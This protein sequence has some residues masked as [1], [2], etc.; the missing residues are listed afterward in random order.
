M[1]TGIEIA[2]LILGS[3]PLIVSAL[4]HYGEG[5]EAMQDWARFRTDFNAFL[6]D[7]IRQ[8]IFF[9][10]HIEDLLS[11][12]VD[13]EYH[14]GRMLDDST[15]EQWKSPV[16][17]HKLKMRL[18]GKQEYESYMVTV[19]AIQ[20]ILS[21]IRKKLRIA[22]E[23]P[24]WSQVKATGL[25]RLGFE[26]KRIVYVLDRKRRTSL[27]DKLSQYNND[28]HQLLD[29]S[30]RLELTRRKR[31]A[32]LPTLFEQFR[33]QAS[34]LHDA[35]SQT[36]QCDCTFLHATK[37][38]LSAGDGTS[39]ML[40]DP[41][42]E[43]ATRLRVYFGQADS[44]VSST[45]TLINHSDRWH[46]A[47]VEMGEADADIGAEA[48]SLLETAAATP[49]RSPSVSQS[50]STYSTRKVSFQHTERR[51]SSN[52]SLVPKDAVRIE[53][54]CAAL[55]QY[56]SSKQ[57]QP[58]KGHLGYLPG[59]DNLCH[60]IYYS[61]DRVPSSADIQDSITVAELL[62]Q[63]PPW[64]SQNIKRPQRLEI[65]L[66]M[67]RV[68][69]QLHSCPWLKDNWTKDDIYFFRDR[70]GKLYLD[71]MALTSKF[72]PAKLSA[73]LEPLASTTSHPSR[74][75]T[76]TSLLSLG[77]LIL[78]MWFNKSIESCN[79]RDR[80]LGPDGEETEFTKFNTA[81]KWQ[82]KALEEGGID[83]DSLT[84]RC[85]YGD[86][87]AAKQDLNDEELRKAVY[88]EV[89]HPLERILARYE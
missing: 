88:Q 57:S 4:E 28:L 59:E 14:M 62:N 5:L 66:V 41:R 30:D 79:F 81:Q 54:L 20:T 29:N 50:V 46:A 32:T 3:F 44:E 21:K 25:S 19:S 71:S 87:G 23:K 77:V 34:S 85:V 64:N 74:K 31:K 15:D 56:E 8:Q 75:R 10:Q 27:M 11:T 76:K 40:K 6:N 7:F 33:R 13:S 49:A 61:Y 45:N 86:F 84:Y 55:K 65:A 70:Q 35:I 63:Q 68:V 17:E 38:L 18:P 26:Y 48:H 58:A 43:D 12:V 51:R 39:T 67:S 36:I 69:L 2:G 78:E 83:L 82:E 72:Y 22:E 42:I 9:R 52:A 1:A 16:L 47:D 24:H 60:T 37:L 73:S 53:D 89:V 80:F